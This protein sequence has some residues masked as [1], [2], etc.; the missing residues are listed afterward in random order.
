[1]AGIKLQPVIQSTRPKGLRICAR[2]H[3]SLSS[4]EFIQTRSL[5]YPEGVVPVCTSCLMKWLD[6][7]TT[8]TESGAPWSAIDKLCQWVD[9]PFVPNVVVD[10]QQKNPQNWL[11]VYAQL[12]LKEEY[13]G[14]GWDDYFKEFTNLKKAG[15]IEE[16]LPL[17]ADEKRE[18]LKQRWGRNY[19][20]E[21]LNYLEQLYNGLLNT[22]NITGALQIDQAIKLCKMS[23]EIDRRIAGGDD[24]DKLL[25]SYDKLVKAA[26]FTP[27]NAKNVNDFESV[28]EL[29]KWAERAGWKN[30]FYDRV[31]RDIVDQTIKNIEAYNQ[32]LYTNES[33]IG[34]E[35]SNRIEQ[36]QSVERMEHI[37]DVSDDTVN[38]DDYEN[39]GY[40]ELKSMMEEEF[41]PD[42][43][44]E[45][46]I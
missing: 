17:I 44:G 28:G 35:I 27:K 31:T 46:R 19:D 23:Y 42:Q 36:L 18:K 11:G 4:A 8:D 22:Q 16:E 30:P 33:G 25:T 24:F 37:Y 43:G 1:M 40:E 29:F 10:I 34:E 13:E 45:D 2:C 41:D 7:Q 3:L 38:L 9:I 20:D 32:R 39:E 26:D 6:E 14:L 5:F 15:T 21:A 12:F